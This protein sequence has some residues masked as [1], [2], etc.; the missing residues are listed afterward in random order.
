M[1]PIRHHNMKFWQL[2]S[3]SSRLIMIAVGTSIL[4]I[5]PIGEESNKEK[6]TRDNKLSPQDPSIQ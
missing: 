3:I 6:K 5:R 1:L 2:G 4:V